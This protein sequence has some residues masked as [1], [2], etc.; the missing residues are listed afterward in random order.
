[1]NSNVMPSHVQMEADEL[2]NLVN[3]VKETVAAE[4][5]D[6]TKKFSVIDLWQIQKQ[7]K[8]ASGNN[9]RWNLN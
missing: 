3:E 4:V 2:K 9:N 7:M 6:A 5:N 8:K 1:M